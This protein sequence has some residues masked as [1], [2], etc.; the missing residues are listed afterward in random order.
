MKIS[1]LPM[2]LLFA[3]L[4]GCAM[5]KGEFP[6]L[7]PRP[8]EKRGEDIAVKPPV[9]DGQAD[10]TLLAK[11]AQLRT[12]MDAGDKSFSDMLP[13]VTQA[14]NAGRSAAG[15]SEKWV[16]AQQMLSAL[17]S[18]RAPTVMAV[19]ELDSLYLAQIDAIAAGRATGGADELRAAQQDGSQLAQKQQVRIDD[20][21]ASL[22]R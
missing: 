1:R 12:Q 2:F 10:A 20:L 16:V 21:K 14:V 4:G 18:A 6:S 22:S 5:E 19:A 17:E 13:R 11:I 7:A 15:G 3:A 8:I 9:Q